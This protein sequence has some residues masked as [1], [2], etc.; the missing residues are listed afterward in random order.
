ML[1]SWGEEFG[2]TINLAVIVFKIWLMD[3]ESNLDIDL[4]KITTDNDQIKVFAPNEYS[5][6]KLYYIG[7][8][9]KLNRF[10]EKVFIF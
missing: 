1:H 2:I 8:E 10:M 3:V 6:E 7:S 5:L 4:I 9:K